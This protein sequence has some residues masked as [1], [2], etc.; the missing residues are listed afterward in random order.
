MPRRRTVRAEQT[1]VAGPAGPRGPRRPG[2]PWFYENPWAWL[3]AILFLIGLGLGIYFGVFYGS[4]SAARTTAP[5]VVGESQA[6]AVRDIRKA[7]LEPA[8][9]QH[10]SDKPAGQVVSQEPGGGTR[11]A[12]GA[13]LRIDVSSGPS[14]TT[15]TQTTTQ[16]TTTRQTTTRQTTT[17]PTTTVQTTTQQTTTQQTTTQSTTT[18]Q[19]TTQGTTTAQATTQGTTTTSSSSG[20]SSEVSVPKVAGKQLLTAVTIVQQAGLYPDASPTTSSKKAG[21]VTAQDPRPG[22]KLKQGKPVRVAVSIGSSNKRAEVKVPGVTGMKADSARLA[23]A[24]TKLTMATKFKKVGASKVGTVLAQQPQKGSNVQAW[25][26]VAI[27]VGK[28]RS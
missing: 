2:P 15:T 13:K 9:N 24:K 25:S 1:T 8:V 23:L 17:Q 19:T 26:Q 16:Q 12:K 4:S 28:P 27:L 10:P 20:G 5:A 11:M 3:V 21:T 6:A 14:T 7:G 22:A 18:T